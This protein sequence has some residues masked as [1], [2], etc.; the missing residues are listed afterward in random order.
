MIVYV[1]SKL[2]AISTL[3]RIAPGEILPGYV[4]FVE[5]L[6]GNS[7]LVMVTKEEYGAY[8]CEEGQLYDKQLAAR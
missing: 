3:V 5:Q 6:L 8:N 7:D 4:A 2:N 1:Q